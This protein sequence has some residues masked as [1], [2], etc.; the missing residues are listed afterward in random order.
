MTRRID[1]AKARAAFERA[2]AGVQ[3]VFGDF[4]LARLIGLEITYPGETCEVAFDVA[5]FMLN[6]Q[7]SLHGGILATALDISMGHLINRQTGPGTT[8]EMK[9]QYLAP[10]RSGRVVC[11]SEA[12]R[13]GGTWFLR[14]EARD[15]EG[16]L[17][18]FA[19]STWKLLKKPTSAPPA[20]TQASNGP[21]GK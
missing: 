13:R 7:G 21:E 17:I 8:L 18:A 4:F 2:A 6:P 19:T 12:L 9:I 11:R 14:A 3:E 10:V 5:D 16:A 1:Q 15:L 20:G